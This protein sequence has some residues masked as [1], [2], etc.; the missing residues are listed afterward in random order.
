MHHHRQPDGHSV[1]SE[2]LGGRLR[3]A[4]PCLTFCLRSKGGFLLTVEHLVDT[5]DR[6]QLNFLPS[7]AAFLQG[8]AESR[9]LEPGFHQRYTHV[10]HQ[11]VF[12]AFLV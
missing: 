10:S 3:A 4:T 7:V 1:G 8:A 12:P 11:T 9:R 6:T 2:L 5:W